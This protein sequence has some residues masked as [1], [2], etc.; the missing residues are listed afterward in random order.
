MVLFFRTLLDQCACPCPLPLSLM[1]DQPLS[2]GV[3]VVVIWSPSHIQLFAAP[4]TVACQASLP[5]TI[6]QSLLKLMSIESVMSQRSTISFSVTPFSCTQSIPA[7]GFFPMS[8]L[9]T[10]GGQSIAH[11]QHSQAFN[12]DSPPLSFLVSPDLIF[13][14]GSV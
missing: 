11:T 5:F 6:S 10:S 8:Q 9:F 13:T 3:V 14:T 4:W 7:S 1:T 2:L 12:P